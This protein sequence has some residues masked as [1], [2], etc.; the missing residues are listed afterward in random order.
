MGVEHTPLELL[1]E[2]EV[3]VTQDR[4]PGENARRGCVAMGT[5]LQEADYR[6]FLI[7]QAPQFRYR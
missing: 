1:C 7:E 4:Q 5:L 3:F 2:G 6:L